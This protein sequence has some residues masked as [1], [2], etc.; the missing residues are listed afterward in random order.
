MT[1]GGRTPPILHLSTLH[2]ASRA[3][4]N[5]RT[6]RRDR[7]HRIIEQQA[8]RF[9]VDLHPSGVENLEAL[10][11]PLPAPASRHLPQ[12][13]DIPGRPQ[14]GHPLDLQPRG[15]PRDLRRRGTH[16]KSPSGGR[17]YVLP[18]GQT[19]TS[20]SASN[21]PQRFTRRF[22]T[23][24]SCLRRL[25]SGG[26]RRR[27]RLAACPVA[28]YP[29]FRPKP[30]KRVS[31]TRWPAQPAPSTAEAISV[32]DL[33]VL[34]S[35]SKLLSL[36]A[37]ATAERSSYSPGE[38]YPPCPH[39]A[40]PGWSRLLTFGAWGTRLQPAEADLHQGPWMR[41]APRPGRPTT[42]AVRVPRAS[43]S[44]LVIRALDL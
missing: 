1:P 24:L 37:F 16:P 29:P 32:A 21:T 14:G 17:H 18:T 39:Q 11:H 43:R 41:S 10:P 36:A 35:E 42:E 2:P 25:C 34:G 6:L 7:G 27:T 13:Q 12:V 44:P 31:A 19:C 38:R 5:V 8:A 28:S 20:A 22:H 33:T 40:N 15:E 3:S 26:F 30:S 4:G 9:P 23:S